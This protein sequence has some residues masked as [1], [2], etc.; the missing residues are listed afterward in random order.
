MRLILVRHGET[1]W[2]RDSRIMG[3]SDIMLTERGQRQ[4]ERLGEA[5]REERVGAVYSSPLTRARQTAEAIA[6]FHGLEVVT[7]KGLMEIHAGD[8][9]GLT[10]EELVTQHAE[11]LKE[12]VA[13]GPT[14][15]VPGG[16]SLD[17]VQR[18]AW[19]TVSKL[20]DLHAS[21]TVVAVSHSLAI[22]S[23]VCKALDMGMSNMRRLHMGLASINILNFERGGV[24]LL[25]YNDTCHLEVAD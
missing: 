1:G 21:E 15:K 2:N 10:Y 16:E 8:L 9:D 7:D 14:L 25:L 13:V 20:A 4:A 24:S 6:L 23:V 18:R 17:D 3:Q 19:A 12:W 11:F 22:Q 5:L